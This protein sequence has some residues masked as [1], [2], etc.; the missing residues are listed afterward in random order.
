MPDEIPCISIT[1]STGTI[2]HQLTYTDS[3]NDFVHYNLI[4]VTLTQSLSQYYV[5]VN[6]PYNVSI[7][8]SWLY[9]TP[10]AGV[11]GNLTICYNL[12]EIGNC[13]II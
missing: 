9:V 7:N 1:E 4:S 5:H 8:D 12:T 13:Y 11:S 3:E 6:T 2:Q 10:P